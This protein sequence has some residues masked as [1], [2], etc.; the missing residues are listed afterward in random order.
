[1][2]IQ[3]TDGILSWDEIKRL[4]PALAR[5]LGSQ[6]EFKKTKG[7]LRILAEQFKQTY[8]DMSLGEIASLIFL[9]Q[10]NQQM[11]DEEKTWAFD[12]IKICDSTYANIP[13][14]TIYCVSVL[15]L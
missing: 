9:K 1:M 12:L 4:I 10:I 2:T 6:T 13:P 14:V 7:L 3:T 11:Q 5:E 15:S 8:K